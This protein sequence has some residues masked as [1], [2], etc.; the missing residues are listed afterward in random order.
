MSRPSGIPPI[1][2]Y[3]LPGPGDLPRNVANWRV[4]QQ[5]VVLLLH[6]FQRYF[7]RPF[8]PPLRDKIVGNAAMIRRRCRALGV[9]VAYTAQPGDMS[10]A[11]RGLLKDIWG[12]GMRAEPQDRAVVDELAPEADDL[13]LTKWRYSAF[14]RSPLLSWMRERGRDQII[15]CGVYAHVGV[16]STAL[17]AFTNDI[18]PFLV[19]DAVGD[20]SAQFHDLA[21]QYAATRCAMVVTAKEML[22]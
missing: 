1:W 21:V 7:L 16:L 3:A 6:D 14:F 8:P 2:E 13:V 15:L 4:D 10:D 5:R 18:Q 11:E 22:L 9:P 12:P 17:E 19:A 20:F